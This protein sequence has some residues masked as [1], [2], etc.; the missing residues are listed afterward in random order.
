M[1][2]RDETHSTQK[3]QTAKVVPDRSTYS[4][5]V[6]L[7]VGIVVLSLGII[8]LL[9]YIIQTGDTHTVRIHEPPAPSP[10]SRSDASVLI[11]LEVEENTRFITEEVESTKSKQKERVRRSLQE[12][13]DRDLPLFTPGQRVELRRADGLIYRGTFL[14]LHDGLA[15]IVNQEERERVPVEKLDRES[16]MRCDVAY[17]ERMLESRVDY[18]RERAP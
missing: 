7:A 2:D 17:R 4:L 5:L 16:R 8:G 9:F 15:L 18:L 11:P 10:M 13:L 6:L 14:G 3:T 1:T 12:A